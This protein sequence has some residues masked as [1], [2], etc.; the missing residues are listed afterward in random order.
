MGNN[1]GAVCELSSGEKKAIKARVCYM[2]A[3]KFLIKFKSVVSSN[4]AAQA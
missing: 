3:N 1:G 4:R 2:G